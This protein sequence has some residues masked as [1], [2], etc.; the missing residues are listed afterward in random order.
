ML[1]STIS[2]FCRELSFLRYWLILSKVYRCKQNAVDR[3]GTCYN[4]LNARSYVPWRGLLIR[5]RRP[6]TSFSIRLEMVLYFKFENFTE[7]KYWKS[8]VALVLPAWTW[9]AWVLFFPKKYAFPGK[10]IWRPANYRF[11]RMPARQFCMVNEDGESNE[12][13]DVSSTDL[14]R[15]KIFLIQKSTIA[16]KEPI[17]KM[18]QIAEKFY[19]YQAG[20]NTQVRSNSSMP[21]IIWRW[22][23]LLCRRQ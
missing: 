16:F 13:K 20:K 7:T 17:K 11:W 4:S 8:S 14:L 1:Y 22:C 10:V 6:S 19:I 5:F 15:S 2:C 23:F 21:S 9:L 12:E 18:Y 3:F